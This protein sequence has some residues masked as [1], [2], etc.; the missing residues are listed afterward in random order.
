MTSPL[1]W[2]AIAL[3][4]KYHTHVLYPHLVLIETDFQAC[5]IERRANKLIPFR[6]SLIAMFATTIQILL[7]LTFYHLQISTLIKLYHI[8]L[9][10][11]ALT[12][13]LL[14]LSFLSVLFIYLDV[15]VIKF[16]N[17]VLQFERRIDGSTRCNSTVVSSL[18]CFWTVLKNGNK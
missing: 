6:I 5:C 17:R 2:S 16:F 13:I 4:N 3:A 14:D 11:A 15:L 1:T 18:R 8:V 7:V 12:I 9:L 10:V